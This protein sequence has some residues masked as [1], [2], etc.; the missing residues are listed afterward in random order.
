MKGKFWILLLIVISVGFYF[1]TAWWAK[2]K[3]NDILT[4]FKKLSAEMDETLSKYRT[5]EEI[6]ADL[7]DSLVLLNTNQN[8]AG[9]EEVMAAYSNSLSTITNIRADFDTFSNEVAAEQYVKVDINTAAAVRNAL[10]KIHEV[11]SKYITDSITKSELDGKFSLIIDC[12][13]DKDFKEKCFE[14]ASPA[15]VVITLLGAFQSKVRQ[16]TEMTLRDMLRRSQK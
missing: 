16:A 12:T 2:R 13:G 5:D 10:L 4:E 3:S 6:I 7:H 14:E 1:G 15:V 8:S 9:V 11:S